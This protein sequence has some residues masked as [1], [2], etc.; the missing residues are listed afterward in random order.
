MLLFILTV[1]EII[2]IAIKVYALLVGTFFIV[3]FWKEREIYA[4]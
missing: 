4:I 2:E 3:Y 1:D